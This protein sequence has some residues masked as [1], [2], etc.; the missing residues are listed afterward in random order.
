MAALTSRLA[1]LMS[2]Q[3]TDAATH[4]QTQFLASVPLFTGIP[5]A[6]LAD[7]SQLLRRRTYDAGEII[8]REGDPAPGMVLIVEGQVSL[9]LTL[10]GDRRVE[11]RRV[12]QA[13]LLGE[14]PLID[15]GTH[16]ATAQAIE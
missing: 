5:E 10:P 7:L 14:V 16:S 13:E 11:F 15:G 1:I 6:E 3:Q 9:S 2:D 8:W 4:E 12:G